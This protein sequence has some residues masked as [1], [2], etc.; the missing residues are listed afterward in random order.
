MPKLT[1][2]DV[3]RIVAE[4]REQGQRPELSGAGL[5]GAGLSGANLRW[6]FL[7]GANLSRVDLSG[8]ILFEANL[9]GAELGGAHLQRCHQMARQLRPHRRRSQP[10]GPAPVTRYSR[11]CCSGTEYKEM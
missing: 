8:A 6:A 9:S 2:A 1:R 4:A 3:E 10:P 5:I 11:C 7:R